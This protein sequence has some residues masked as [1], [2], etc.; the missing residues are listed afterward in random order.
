MLMNVEKTQ[1]VGRLDLPP[2]SCRAYISLDCWLPL[3]EQPNNYPLHFAFQ[4]SLEAKIRIDPG[5]PPCAGRTA[6]F[7]AFF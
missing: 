2:F 3:G 5:N 1:I 4:L 7:S 6:D